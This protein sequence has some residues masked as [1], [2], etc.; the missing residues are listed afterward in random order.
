MP[1]A[2]CATVKRPRLRTA[3]RDWRSVAATPVPKDRAA[4]LRDSDGPSVR[5]LELGHLGALDEEKQTK[6][7]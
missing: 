2:H 4:C 6:A 7:A 1:R 3:K 5:E